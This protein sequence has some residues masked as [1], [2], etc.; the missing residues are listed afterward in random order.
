M[1][2]PLNQS[3]VSFVNTVRENYESFTSREVEKAI[4]ARKTHGRVGNPSCAEFVKMV[5]EKTVKMC[6]S[7]LLMFLTHLPFLVP[8]FP[9]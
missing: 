4:L 9:G 6:L 5:S 3:D 1:S 2:Q 7:H 8:T